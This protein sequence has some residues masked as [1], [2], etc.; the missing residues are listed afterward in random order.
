M[1][2]YIVSDMHL[3]FDDS[4]FTAQQMEKAIAFLNRIRGKADLLIMNGDIFDFW[5][6]WKGSII[7]SY[8]PF[9]KAL[10]DLKESG[11]RPV[12]IAGNHDF[13]FRDF[14]TKTI[15]VELCMESFSGK[16]DGK[17]IFVA[18]GDRYTSNDMRYHFYR[19]IIR[20]PLMKQIAGLFHPNFVLW[21]VKHISNSSRELSQTRQRTAETENKGMIISAKKLLNQFD[22]VCFAH[23]HTPRIVELE[24]GI[25]ANSGDWLTNNTYLSLIDGELN[26]NFWKEET[27]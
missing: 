9:L 25:Y 14:L 16:M 3:G 8:F 5:M 26:L 21:L 15:G 12:F 4:E 19:S 11:C 2:V 7:S 17:N 22:I 20:F 24:N 18:H 6:E 23:S 1:R 10:A 27:S 13:W